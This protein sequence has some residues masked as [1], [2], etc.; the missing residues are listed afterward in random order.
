MDFAVDY[1]WLPKRG[2]KK[3]RRKR[4][5]R[6]K[7][8]CRCGCGARKNPKRRYVSGHS[9]YTRKEATA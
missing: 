4:P 5:G 1:S 2:V 3:A 9:A 7:N 6:T 8:L